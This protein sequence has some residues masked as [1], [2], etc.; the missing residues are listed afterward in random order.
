MNVFK[1]LGA[2]IALMAACTGAMAQA[3]PFPT[4]PI[5]LI[6]PFAVGGP[7]DILAR[8]LGETLGEKLGQPVIVDNKGGAGGSIGSE[9]VAY[10][11]PDGYTIGPVSYTHLTLPTKA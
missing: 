4:K 11:A 9:A 8:I 1:Q 10:S 2:T 7:T 5:K 6:V 3:E